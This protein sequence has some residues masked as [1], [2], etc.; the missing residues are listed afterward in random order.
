M[1]TKLSTILFA[2]ALAGTHDFG[3]NCYPGVQGTCDRPACSGIRDIGEFTN[4][5][6]KESLDGSWIM[7]SDIYKGDTKDELCGT[8]GPI[9]AGDLFTISPKIPSPWSVDM[10]NLTTHGTLED[11]VLVNCM[12]TLKFTS[13]T[14]AEGADE[15]QFKAAVC[16]DK[17]A[18]DERVATMTEWRPIFDVQESALDNIIFIFTTPDAGDYI[19]IHGDTTKCKDIDYTSISVEFAAL[20]H[21]GM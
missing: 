13:Y 10:V 2:S 7:V 6:L 16:D 12:S 14:L 15:A 20:A 5:C 8:V 11:L 9:K 1:V 19:T 18:P 3:F 17:K 4:C 21:L